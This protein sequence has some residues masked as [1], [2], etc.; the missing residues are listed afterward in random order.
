MD[1]FK[2]LQ[3]DRGICSQWNIVKYYRIYHPEQCE[4]VEKVLP[5]MA[6]VF[7]LER[8]KTSS[9]ESEFG[10][11]RNGSVG[12]VPTCKQEGLSLILWHPHKN[13]CHTCG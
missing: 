8:K 4:Y 11:L 1:A 5:G 7:Y 12:K 9:S 6:R 10:A 2:T 13:V 3:S